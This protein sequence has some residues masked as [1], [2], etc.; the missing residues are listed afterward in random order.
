MTNE[1]FYDAEIAPKLAAIGSACQERGMSIAAMVEFS[2]GE[3]GETRYTAPDASIKTLIAQWGIQCH[4]NVDSLLIAIERHARQYGHSS[5]F[6]SMRG[7]PTA[8]GEEHG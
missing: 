6:L 2:P 7:V 1:Q 8:P 5:M 4:G 3:S